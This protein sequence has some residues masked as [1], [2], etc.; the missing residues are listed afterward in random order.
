MELDSR[1]QRGD[2]VLVV[3]LDRAWRSVLDCLQCVGRWETRG[4]NLTV[5]D[6]GG[7]AV[8]LSTPLGRFMLHVLAAAAEFERNMIRARVGEGVRA[9]RARGGIFKAPFGWRIA[10]GTQPPVLEPHPV[11]YPI[12]QE[13]REGRDRGLTWAALARALNARGAR[14]RRGSVFDA[15]GVRRIAAFAE[16]NPYPRRVSIP[17]NAP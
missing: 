8:D 1:L 10:A 4:V 5:L 11:E 13:I 12:L 6:L 2:T 9:C 14:N 16:V 15:D 17:E 3:R 7:N